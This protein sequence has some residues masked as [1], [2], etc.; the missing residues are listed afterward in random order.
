MPLPHEVPV[1]EEFTAPAGSAGGHERSFLFV[2]A[3]TRKNGN[4]EALAEHAAAALPGDV[5]QE[6]FRLS[7]SPMS[8]FEDIRHTGSGEY[9]EPT[10]NDRLLW[11]AT[12]AA[13]DLVI[14]SPL[15]WYSLTASAKLYLDHWSGWMR[16]PGPS[17]KAEMGGKTLWGITALASEER[18]K[19]DPLI[20]TLH[21]CARYM[22]MRWGGVL[23]GNGTKPGQIHT[24][25]PAVE[26][27]GR[28]FGRAPVDSLAG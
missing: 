12:R 21:N 3:S 25:L 4:S 10:G 16:V 27:A 28:F 17:F 23:L 1:S 5:R 13:T 11:E 26:E 7:E 6:W 24:D 15:Y 2:L 9:P 18:A 14:V 22:D 20:G 8:P 19:A